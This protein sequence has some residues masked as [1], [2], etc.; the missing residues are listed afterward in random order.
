[1][2]L[3]RLTII[4]LLLVFIFS[5]ASGGSS[6][7]TIPVIDNNPSAERDQRIP[8]ND[9]T[10]SM[11]TPWGEASI[12][13]SMTSHYPASGWPSN[14][15]YK[16][17][18]YGFLSVTT[19]AKHPG[20]SY[21]PDEVSEA[22]PYTNNAQWFEA[23]LNGDEYSDLIYIGNNCCNRDYV[24]E[25]LMLTFINNGE[26]HFE[27]SSDIF[28]D[29]QFPCVNGGKSW[30]SN[31][32]STLHPCGNQAD[33]TNGKIVAD[34]NGD[35]MSDYYDTS[36]L[37]LSNTEGKLVNKSFS[38]L[39]ELFFEP[40]HGQI[41]V[42]DAAYGDLDGDGDLDIF[43]PISDYTKT[44]Y[45]F[46]GDEDPCS[47]CV[48][49]I[50]FT[51]LINDGEG[52]FEANHLLPQFDN[53]V[54]VDYDNWG[55][56]IDQL[57]PTTATIGDFDNDGYGDIAL[58]W[59]NPIIADRYGFS[60]NSSGVVYFNDGN[61]DWTKR[62]HVELPE[63]FFGD[64]GNANDME[65]MDFNNDGY[66]DILLASTIHEPYYHSRV[67]QFFQNDL[68]RSF[69]DITSS[70]SPDHKKYAD[71]NPYSQWWVGQ[72]KLHILDYDHDGDLDIVDTN[73]RTSVYLNNQN[74]FDLYDNF[75]DTDEDVL[76]WPVE[77]DGKY[78]YDFI[79][80]HN[81]ICNQE[82]CTTNFYQLLDP[83]SSVL[84]DDFF[85][86]TQG[87]IDSITQASYLGDFLREMPDQSKIHYQAN[88]STSSLG[89]ISRNN[90]LSVMTGR[91]RGLHNGN[92]L[93]VIFNQ[94]NLRFGHI[95][96]EVSTYS[97]SNTKWFGRGDAKLSLFI[98]E[99]FLE[100]NVI[101]LAS[102][103]F[104]MGYLINS[105]NVDNFSE[106]G[107]SVNLSYKDNTFNY[108]A[109]FLKFN[110]GVDF[111]D[112]SINLSGGKRDQMQ[113]QRFYMSSQDGLVFQSEGN[114]SNEYLSF[115][116][117]RDFYYFQAIKGSNSDMKFVGGIQV[118]F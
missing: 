7:E 109:K 59:F 3:P 6:Q 55:N 81:Q 32:E 30:L 4:G 8:F 13:Y 80:S 1:M 114:I 31:N 48:E 75:V 26:G 40:N 112:F 86:K 29:N 36:I 45:R 10:K 42:H 104:S 93:G 60:K 107:S 87:F 92:Y 67:I 64:N 57:W 91:L 69:I 50:P 2:K 106:Q 95:T 56:N 58:G 34:F 83:P 17:E 88:S 19:N 52:N 49:N 51:M 44:G 115:N 18:D 102:F 100:L 14:D 98:N 99:T 110:Y 79:G 24:L 37:Y 9:F 111:N 27:L 54:E 46:G 113:H 108:H 105:T 70:I 68:G 20:D 77:I 62:Q 84:A 11:S 21:N 63:N 16:I 25:D 116:I 23:D 97:N 47:G 15:K 103:E 76:L 89:Y 28:L 94:K 71:G 43:V 118:N 5:C 41:F 22:G 65:V 73:T 38:N 12:E 53:W 39:P 72:G 90:N 66:M 61:N 74:S 117:V 85:Q 101:Q 78:H 33:Y 96:S 82:S 35:G